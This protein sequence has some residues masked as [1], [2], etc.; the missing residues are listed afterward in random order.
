MDGTL[1]EAIGR[2]TGQ[3]YELETLTPEGVATLVRG[4][5]TLQ[6]RVENGVAIATVE[7]ADPGA[8]A[9]RTLRLMRYAGFGVVAVLLAL[10]AVAVF[11]EAR[12]DSGGE[13][14][15]ARQE[16][17]PEATAAAGAIPQ[18]SATEPT[19]TPAAPTA[20]AIEAAATPRPAATATL[21]PGGRGP[22]IR[23]GRDALPRGRRRRP[24]R[25]PR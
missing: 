8:R 24:G 22:A 25:W 1:L 2:Y 6:L 4:D 21:T 19:V 3:G 10:V 15:N 14:A 23:P 7:G 18:A 11:R 13:N 17:R 20:T 12:T 16:Q 9:G 5:E